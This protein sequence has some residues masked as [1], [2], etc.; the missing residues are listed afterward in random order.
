[1]KKENYFI[2]YKLAKLTL[3]KMAAN[4]YDHELSVEEAKIYGINYNKFNYKKKNI[5]CCF[6]RD[7]PSGEYIWNVLGIEKPIIT[8][9]ELLEISNVIRSEKAEDKNYEEEFLRMSICIN[10]MVMKFYGCKMGKSVAKELKVKYDKDFDLCEGMVDTYDNLQES[11]GMSAWQVLGYED[12]I[13]ASSVVESKHTEL[14]E[15]LL[16]LT[17][18]NKKL[19]K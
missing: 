18:N 17:Q 7:E 4:F 16:K 1:M 13:V 2:E 15:K 11:T 19:V 12:Q 9:D 3:A 10:S 8:Y 5:S 14:T 6:H